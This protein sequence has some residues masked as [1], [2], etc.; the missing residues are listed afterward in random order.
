MYYAQ[1]IIRAKGSSI[2]EVRTEGGGGVSSIEDVVREV[3]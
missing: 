3:A 2:Y 1:R